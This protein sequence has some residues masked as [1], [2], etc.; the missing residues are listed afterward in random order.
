[1]TRHSWIGAT[2]VLA[3]ALLLP[4]EARAQFETPNRAF[5][6]AFSFKL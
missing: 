5:H 4:A 2:F 1:M 6:N 3:L